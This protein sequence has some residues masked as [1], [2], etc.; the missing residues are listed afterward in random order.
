MQHLATAVAP[1][2]DVQTRIFLVRAT[3][4]A[5]GECNWPAARGPPASV[6]G[7]RGQN[8]KPEPVLYNAFW[9]DKASHL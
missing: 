3:S 9:S 7:A 4:L 2:S 1:P 6:G 5:N 8:C